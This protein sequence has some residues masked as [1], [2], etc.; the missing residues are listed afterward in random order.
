MSGIAGIL[1]ASGRAVSAEALGHVA[2]A[3]A[4]RGADGITLWRNGPVGLIRFHHATTP[5]AVGERQPLTGPSGATIAFD[6]RL[7]NRAELI[8]LLGRRGETLRA[9]PD[10]DLALALF[11]QAGDGFLRHLTGDWALAIWQPDARRLFCARSPAGWR[12]FLFTHDADR[13]AFASEPRALV[14]G[15]ALERRL[16]EAM[17]AEHLTQRVVTPGETF[18]EGVEALPQGAALDYRGGM[19]RRWHWDNAP[20]EDLT[21]ASEGEHI[22]RF[23]DLFDQA[24]VACSRS[25]TGVAAQLSGG[26]DS[27]SVVARAV[28]LNR[29]GRIAAPPTAISAHFPG[30]P[31]DE[32]AY[33]NAVAQDLRLRLRIVSGGVFDPD[34]ARAWSAATLYLPLRPNTIDTQQRIFADLQGRGERVLLSGEG[35]DEFLN[36]NHVHWADEIRRG[37]IDLIAREALAMPGKSPLA[38][39][40][41]I[42]MESLGPHLSNARYRRA[43]HRQMWA[44]T[45]IQDWLRPEWI[46]QTGVS[47]RIMDRRPAR[48]LPTIAAQN[49]YAMVAYPAR[50]TL[51]G[52]SQAFAARH[53]VEHRH[54]LYDIRLQRFYLGAS[55]AVLFKGGVRR[56]LLREAM[57]GTLV[58]QVRTRTTK[59]RF[60]GA[61]IEGLAALYAER[62]IEQQWPVRLGWVDGAKL[63]AIWHRLHE[64]HLHG[65][66]DARPSPTFGALWN[67]AALDIWL[68]HG[69]GL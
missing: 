64:S 16:N 45:P 36:G 49:R 69:F 67:V 5:E 39:L 26:L 18:F 10:C 35:G 59:A 29:A 14:V 12:P 4:I 47:H 46:A 25:S 44:G 63:A 53:G 19:L 38:R 20:Y 61:V 43:A 41:S 50:D 68:E 42:V 17:I 55:G 28:H 60:D 2:D 66:G 56:H 32:S 54:P 6:G 58:E 24:L 23:T 57:R 62:P 22:E 31:I 65:S 3:A 1:Y 8:A 30:S 21:R 15:L 13:L 52:A 48:T 11:E 27:S 51:F 37:R 7:D 34:V 40:R 9:C 33:S